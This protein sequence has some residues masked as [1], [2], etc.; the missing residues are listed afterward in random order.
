MPGVVTLNNIDLA[1]VTPTER[2]DIFDGLEEILEQ[3]GCPS[4][5]DVKSCEATVTSVGGVPRNGGR[6]RRFLS[7]A[8]L[9]EYELVI[10]TICASSDCSDVQTLAN[11]VFEEVTGDLLEA[12]TDGTV[13][14][15]LQEVSTSLETLLE[16]VTATGEFSEVVVPLLALLVKWYPDWRGQ[17]GTCKND[18]NAPTY[19]KVFGIY[20][21]S[22]LDACCKRYFGWDLSVCNGSSGPVP[23]GFFPNWG[24]TEQRC[25]NSTESPNLL[26]NYMRQNSEQWLNDDVGTCCERHFNWVYG[27]CIELSGGN[28]SEIATNKWYVNQRDEVCQRDCPEGN[29]GSCGG[30]ARP[31]NALYETVAN[32]CAQ[33]LSW[34]SPETC[35]A[36]SS[37]VAPT[38]TSEWFIDWSLEKCVKDCVDPSDGNCGGLAMRWDK[39]HQTANECCRRLWFIERDQCTLE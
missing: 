38:G 34:I 8:L 4:S 28:S 2:E 39:R 30:L 32:C 18:G 11:Q 25:I 27:D 37:G 1:D 15:S 29:G 16:D 23:S 19:M 13:V 17:S 31:W 12:I 22:S 14:S 21:E 10:E 24:G 3:R 5:A 36:K 6:L 7:S 20:F 9:I 33:K 26:P 35:E